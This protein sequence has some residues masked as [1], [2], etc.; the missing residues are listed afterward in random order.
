MT[1]WNMIR[2]VISNKLLNLAI[3]AAPPEEKPL[4]ALVVHEYV[5]HLLSKELQKKV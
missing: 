5:R 3:S 4:L 2:S 1:V